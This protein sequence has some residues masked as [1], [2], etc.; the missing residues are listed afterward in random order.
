MRHP[1]SRWLR[2]GVG[3]A[4]GALVLSVSGLAV[5]AFA[6]QV[7]QTGGVSPVAASGT[8]ELNINVQPQNVRELKQ[9][10]TTMYAVGQF[11]SIVQGGQTF[12]RN[13]ILSFSATAPYTLSS[14][15]PDVNGTVN[16]IAFDGANCSDAYIGGHFTSVNGTPAFNI[17]KIDTTTGNVVSGFKHS[18]NAEVDTMAVSGSH[19]LTGG[20]FTKIN[21]SSTRY[22]A[23]LNVTTGS[24]DGY[25]NFNISGTYQY[26]G[27]D[28]NTTEI[29]NQQVSHGG[30]RVM[31]E[32]VFTSVAGQP[33]QQ[34][35]QEW[36]GPT[37]AQVTGWTMPEL[38]D[39]CVTREPFYA[40]AAAWAPNDLTA[41]IATTGTHLYLWSAP[42]YPLTGPC[43]AT[44]AVSTAEQSENP[45]WANYTGCDSL[46]AVVADSVNVYVA[47]HPRWANNPDGCNVKGPGAI[48]D[49][50]LQGLNPGTGH[51]V[52]NAQGTAGLYSAARDNADDAILTS[53]GLW[54]ASSNR[55]GSE[56][57]GGVSGVSGICFLPYS[58]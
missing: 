35:F 53:A 43:D 39:H 19:L 4:A 56:T 29:Y 13:N 15:A 31:V 50:G 23:S 47:G 51:V 55:F 48:S 5:P 16:T 45:L 20:R 1:G 6:V 26:S 9:C 8:P 12:T 17:A 25:I 44:T 41:Y 32:G 7:D 30:A 52:T 10:G 34:V 49:P 42:N 2:G 37:K 27:V 46:Y 57:C 33:R 11:T 36:L 18:A 40:Q 14:W 38:N 21:N 22:Y 3:A 58:G 24:N 54:V 28:P